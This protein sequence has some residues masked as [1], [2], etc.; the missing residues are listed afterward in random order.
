MMISI[1]CMGDVKS[2]V[3][4]IWIKKDP[5][6]ALQSEHIK[7]L[8]QAYRNWASGGHDTT[9]HIYTSTLEDDINRILI[10]RDSRSIFVPTR[11]CIKDVCEGCE[12]VYKPIQEV[13]TSDMPLYFRIDFAKLTCPYFVLKNS[14]HACQFCIATDLDIGSPGPNATPSH[15]G[16]LPFS[17]QKSVFYDD[18]T[19]GHLE[20]YGIVMADGGPDVPFENSLVVYSR[21]VLE[22]MRMSIQMC[23]DE[24]ELGCG[25][26]DDAVCAQ[27]V[28]SIVTGMVYNTMAGKTDISRLIDEQELVPTKYV[29]TPLSKFTPNTGGRDRSAAWAAIAC[30]AAAVVALSFV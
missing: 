28:Y 21:S 7:G 1:I 3:C 9:I 23:I 29:P 19:L 18:K 26:Y 2:H 14:P 10:F 22:K 15:P 12:G 13:L 30:G 25:T 5:G 8:K 27:I 20:E 24:A 4:L 11:E 16:A 6:A 17:F